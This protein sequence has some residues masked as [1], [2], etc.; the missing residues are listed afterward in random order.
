M[1]T[2]KDKDYLVERI[3]MNRFGEVDDIAKLVLFFVSDMNTYVTG[4]NIIID[5]GY[6]INL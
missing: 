6:T 3:P 5:G 2:Q 4:Q 1:L